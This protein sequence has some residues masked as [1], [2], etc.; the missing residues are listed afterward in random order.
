[1][2]PAGLRLKARRLR[3]SLNAPAFQWGDFRRLGPVSANYGSDRGQPIDRYYYY[4][5]RFLAEHRA[6]IKG[7]VLEIQN[8]SYTT[9]FRKEKVLLKDVLDI[10]PRNRN[11]THI[12]KVETADNIP[13]R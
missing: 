13:F 1:M 10:D 6:D 2:L 4:M 3:R 11:A 5:E 7:K 8:S 9:I 12:E